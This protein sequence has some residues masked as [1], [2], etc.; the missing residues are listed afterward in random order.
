VGDSTSVALPIT[1][2]DATKLDWGSLY[3]LFSPDLVDN[4]PNYHHDGVPLQNG[5]NDPIANISAFLDLTPSN[6]RKD[7]SSQ[8]TLAFDQRPRFMESDKDDGS[9]SA[10]SARNLNA[11]V[12]TGCSQYRIRN[13]LQVLPTNYVMF[14]CATLQLLLFSNRLVSQKLTLHCSC[15]CVQQFD[16]TVQDSMRSVEINRGAVSPGFLNPGSCIDGGTSSIRS[17]L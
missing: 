12:S 16:P 13:W 7:L 10:P 1:L 6:L 2:A 8:K 5:T 9:H 14:C 11:L 4:V 3:R 15:S 17:R